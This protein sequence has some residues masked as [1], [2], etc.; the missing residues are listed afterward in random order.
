MLPELFVVDVSTSLSSVSSML[1][2][3]MYEFDIA[4]LHLAAVLEWERCNDSIPIS[5]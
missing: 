4:K 5:A 2:V 3:G 1:S